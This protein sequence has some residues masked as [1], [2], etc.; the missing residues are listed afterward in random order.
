MTAIGANVE[1]D[2]RTTRVDAE[3]A[4]DSPTK[5][6]KLEQGLVWVHL[7]NKEQPNLV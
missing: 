7:F 4:S 1:L 3:E 6:A 5:N 2:L